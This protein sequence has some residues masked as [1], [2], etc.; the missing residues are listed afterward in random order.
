VAS[1]DP[2]G[3]TREKL[4]VLSDWKE[5][6]FHSVEE[7]LYWLNEHLFAYAELCDLLHYQYEKI[8]IAGDRFPGLMRTLR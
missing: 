1:D 5:R 8:D 3:K 4:L 7:A 6:Q 2:I